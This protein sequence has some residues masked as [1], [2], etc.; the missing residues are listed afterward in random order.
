MTLHDFTDYLNSLPAR[1]YSGDLSRYAIQSIREGRSNYNVVNLLDFCANSGREMYLIDRAT[2]DAFKVSALRDI[3]Q[4]LSMLMKRYCITR[5]E[6]C[7]KSKINYL[8]PNA[9][10]LKIGGAVCDIPISIKTLLAV[11]E[12]AHCEI[13]IHTK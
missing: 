9:E 11:C 5:R 3:H 7:L 2:E 1:E 6:L 13:A 8:M 10:D 4:I 12:A